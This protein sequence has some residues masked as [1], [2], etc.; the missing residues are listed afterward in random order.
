MKN[1]FLIETAFDW[2]I[3]GQELNWDCSYAVSTLQ[4]AQCE[5]LILRK[6]EEERREEQRKKFGKVLYYQSY[7]Y[8]TIHLY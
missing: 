6:E 7:R 4:S 3:F 8:R 2:K 1:I 5:M